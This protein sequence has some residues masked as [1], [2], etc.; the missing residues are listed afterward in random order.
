MK[1]PIITNP[2]GN[3]NGFS[4]FEMDSRMIDFCFMYL[5]IVD[6]FAKEALLRFL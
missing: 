2:H 6:Y 1:K 4:C 5:F 3:V